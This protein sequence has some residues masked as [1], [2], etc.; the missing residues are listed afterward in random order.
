MAKTATV[1]I[2]S[3]DF[4]YENTPVRFVAIRSCPE[5][6]LAGL[7]L[8][9]IEE[10]NEYEVCHWVAEEL[11]K[12]GLARFHVEDQLDAVK[13]SK[14]QWTER[15]Q[16]AGQISKLPDGFYPKLRRCLAGLRDEMAHSP[17]KMREYERAGH[18]ARDI[19]NSRLKKIVS[20][21]SAPAQTE[22]SLRNFTGEERLVYEQLFRVINGWKAQILDKKEGA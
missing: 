1:K 16:A 5:I 21:A 4:M 13:L 12:G 18:L 20:I 15:V 22:S 10:G 7:S 19:V 3:L 14:I 9:P 11:A 8:V 17:E 6:Q 2:K